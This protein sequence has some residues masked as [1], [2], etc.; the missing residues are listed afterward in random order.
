MKLSR[1]K[2]ALVFVS[3]SILVPAWAWSDAPIFPGPGTVNYVAGQ[4]AIGTEALKPG[5]GGAIALQTGQSLTT[6]TGKAE[7]LLM[8]GVFARLGEHSSLKMVS[9]A[10]PDTEIA[11][12]RG[13][14]MVEII[15]LNKD[16][17]L[18]VMLAG[19]PIRLLKTGLYELDAQPGRLR[20][21][22]GLAGRWLR[23][24]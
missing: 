15:H 21:F 6:E 19:A 18:R 24:S 22:D 10:S 8:P 20:V 5:S 11:V 3:L 17:N 12:E 13:R 4:A 1:L 7:V 23:Q 2:A 14:V 9:P 16:E